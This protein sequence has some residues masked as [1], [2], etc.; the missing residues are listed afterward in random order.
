[1]KHGGNVRMTFSVAGLCPRTGEIG[2][3]LA[4]SSMAAGARAM[5]LAPG[6][7]A[8][9]AQ[10]R[11][12]PALGALGRARLEAGRSADETV[13]DML[14]AA[15]HRAWRQLGVLDA[16]GRAA[17]HTG[18]HCVAAKGAVSAPGALAIGNGLANDAVVPAILRGFQA[19]PDRPLV[20]RLIAALNAGLDAGGE[21]YPLR[22]A[23]LQV[24]RPGIPFPVV[25]LRVDLAEHPLADLS[26]YW[27]NYAP[28]LEGYLARAIDPA[29]A[30]LAASFETHLRQPINGALPCA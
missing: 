25:D 6:C 1:M 4:T 18:E 10:A 30:P 21:P 15:P 26:R 27:A 9:F 8:V 20:E 5:F 12:D 23:A 29:N 19:D 11:S 28:L 3:A 22:S 24:S 16:Q 13:A 2:L 17:H 14:A 7:G